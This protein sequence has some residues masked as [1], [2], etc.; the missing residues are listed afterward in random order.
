[1]LSTYME[2]LEKVDAIFFSLSAMLDSMAEF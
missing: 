2:K 1:V